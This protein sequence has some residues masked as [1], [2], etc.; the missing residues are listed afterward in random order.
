M[1]EH[2]KILESN[3]EATRCSLGVADDLLGSLRDA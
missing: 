1:A 2:P 3:F